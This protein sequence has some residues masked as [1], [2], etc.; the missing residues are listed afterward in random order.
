ML[1]Y[2]TLEATAESI[3]EGGL[4]TDDEVKGALSSLL[5]YSQDPSTVIGDPRIFQV[6]ARHQLMACVRRT[7]RYCSRICGRE[8]S[9]AG[10]SRRDHRHRS[11]QRAGTC[12]RT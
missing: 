3:V 10:R 9:V 8:R 11:A 1:S 7:E 5:T 2:L 4:A 6:W 12:R